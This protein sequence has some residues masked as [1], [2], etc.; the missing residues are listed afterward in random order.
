MGTS[1]IRGRA[2][3]P[4]A[5]VAAAAA[6]ALLATPLPAQGTGTPRTALLTLT[7]S[8]S[9]AE[10]GDQVAAV[11][12]RV[13]HTLDLSDSLVVELPAGA[14]V[15]ASAAEVPDVT[16]R[17]NG[18]R[19][20][21]DV[22]VPTYRETIGAPDDPD[23][24]SGVTVALVDTGV[25]DVPGLDHVEHVNVTDGP[26]GDG[27]GHGTFLAGLIGATGSMPGVAPGAALLDVQV[28]D[29]KGNTSLSAV[30][31]GLEEVAERDVDVVNVSLSTGS[32]LPPA[33][34]PLSRALEELWARGV[35]VVVAAG[36]EGPDWGTV[37]SPG[38]DPV[39]L[40]VGSIDEGATAQREGDTVAEFSA[41]GSFSDA[42]K[43][44]LV[45]PG[46]SL[47]ST[48]APDS[49]AVRRN[50][51]ALLED[52]YMRGSGTSMSAAVV[53]GAVA[54][55]L[56]ATD[57]A[58]EP[59]G[60]KALLKATTYGSPELELEDGAGAGALDLAAALAAAGQAAANPDQPDPVVPDGE[61]GPDQRDAQAWAAFAEAWVE[62]DF[63][64]VARAW[65]S[66][67]PRTR[68]WAA[69]AW[70]MAVVAN[71]LTVDAEEFEARAWSAR[72]WSAEEWLA[73]AW[74]ARA[75]SD[76]DWLARAWSARAWSDE[77]W[78]A[79]AWSARAWSGDDWAARAWS[80]RAWSARAWCARAWSARAWSAGAWSARAWS[81][82]VWEAR[83]WS[84]RAW[85]ARAWSAHAWSRGPADSTA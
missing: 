69:R 13:L 16:M 51:K 63:E 29:P 5:V 81:E 31:R 45:A 75:W 68:I 76:E 50:R 57:G 55:V 52:G 27:L 41:R 43:P 15:P 4:T 21:Y 64:A 80:A 19:T 84:A 70:S 22:D 11:G 46:V 67:A 9:L 36:N 44:D 1:G 30:L 49:I 82:Y 39:L 79:R 85:S 40:T 12:G 17:V 42:N 14:A 24:G 60:V 74:S 47:V 33:Y 10:L 34:D 73:R 65:S 83:A 3:G 8:S 18:V 62:G 56:D 72:A 53:T 78:L 26:Q 48:A 66:L 38:N 77:D 37:D 25:A 6:L 7:G 20:Y 59:N 32:P 28:A 58:L 54:A 35:T 2:G 23:T 71:S 61:F